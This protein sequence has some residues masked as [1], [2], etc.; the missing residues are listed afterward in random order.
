M[1][2]QYLQRLTP[3]KREKQIERAAFHR[4]IASH[5]HGYGSGFS[6]ENLRIQGKVARLNVQF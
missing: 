1:N 4:L 2:T 3:E 6:R 5:R